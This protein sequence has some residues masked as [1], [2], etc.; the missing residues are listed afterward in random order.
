VSVRDGSQRARVPGESLGEE[1]VPRGPINI[2]DGG[3]AQ[4]VEGVQPVEPGDDLPGAEEGRVP[5]T[6]KLALAGLCCLA[7]LGERSRGRARVLSEVCPVPVG[8]PT[9]GSDRR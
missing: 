9:I 1:E 5:T 8:R 6:W 3:M 2:G 7:L 4:R